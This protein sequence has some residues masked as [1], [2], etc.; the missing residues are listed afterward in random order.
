MKRNKLISLVLTAAM[1]IS[2][3]AGCAGSGSGGASSSPAASPSASTSTTPASSAPAESGTIR[4][5]IW[6]EDTMTEEI[7]MHEGFKATFEKAHPGVTV[8]PAYYKYAPDTFVPMVQSKNCPT[9]FESWFTEPQKL[10]RNGFVK[11]ITD[12]LEERGWLDKITP[13]VRSLLSDENGRVYGVPRDAYPLGMMINLNLFEQ[14][15][16]MNADGTPQYPKTW[17]ELALTA[18]KIQKATGKAGLVL[19]AKDNAGGWHWSNIAWAFGAAQLCIDNGDGTFTSNLAS[20]EA[21]AAMQYIKDLK[22]KYNVLTADP[23]TEDWGSGFT[24]L[25][26]GAA[27]MY[28]GAVDAVMQPT[29]A[30]GLAVD[31]LALVPM[32]EGPG[33]QYSLLGGTPYMFPSYATDEEVNWCLDYLEI[34]GKGPIVTDVAL[35]GMM[36]DAKYRQDNGIPVIPRFPCYTGEIVEAENKI[37]DEYSNVN[38]ALFNDYFNITKKEGNLKP[39]E[40]GQTQDMYAA[41]TSVLQAVIT[42]KNADVTVLMTQANTDYQ[43]LLD[44]S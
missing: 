42:D 1:L 38:M 36:A 30:N 18:Q 12:I 10:I 17:D 9:V 20:P 40:P 7:K 19:L 23:T 32:P 15:G 21:I 26:T 14:A 3:L 5:G 11:D 24:A 43:T 39:E 29:Y 28:I 33:G 41:I 27:A 2:L 8:E 25:G 44:A 37:V 34:M 16:L 13:S 6:P 35:D 22:W 4:L 31:K